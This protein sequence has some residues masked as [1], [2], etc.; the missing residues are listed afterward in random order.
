M[1]DS[2]KMKLT[3]Y[4]VSQDMTTL[5]PEWVS[6]ANAHQRLYYFLLISKKILYFNKFVL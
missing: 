3:D 6:E 4:D 1:V 5:K 2:G